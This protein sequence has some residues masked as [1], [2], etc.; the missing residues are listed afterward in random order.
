VGAE[1]LSPRRGSRRELSGPRS[2]S[3][4]AAGR[5][6][7]KQPCYAPRVNTLAVGFFTVGLGILLGAFG[8]HGLRD[9]GAELLGFWATA[10]LYHFIGGFGLVALGLLQLVR[11]VATWPGIALLIGIV[12]FSGSLYAMTLGAPRILGAVTPVGGTALIVGFFG[13]GAQ[14]LKLGRAARRPSPP[15]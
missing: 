7:T 11:P 6:A 2:E 8:A 4:P 3:T 10:T 15:K 1:S 9:L 5:N 13:L 14:A 12:S